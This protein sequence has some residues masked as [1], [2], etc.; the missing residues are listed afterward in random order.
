M[1]APMLSMYL[2]EFGLTGARAI[3]WLSGLLAGK[4]GHAPSC[5]GAPEGAFAQATVTSAAS[6]ARTR[7]NRLPRRSGTRAMLQ[8]ERQ[9]DGVCAA[10]SCASTAGRASTCRLAPQCQ[11]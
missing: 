4:I 2:A 8:R 6:R 3:S 5:G 11:Q 1:L 10:L 7:R 9:A